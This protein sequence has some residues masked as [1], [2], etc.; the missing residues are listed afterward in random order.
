[1]TRL[2]EISTI[3]N[4]NKTD[5]NNNQ[6]TNKMDTLIH[7]TFTKITI[8]NYI[9]KWFEPKRLS[10]YQTT[11]NKHLST[12]LYKHLHGIKTNDK[13]LVV[14]DFPDYYTDYMYE[15]SQHIT[16]ELYDACLWFDGRRFSSVYL[17]MILDPILKRPET[18]HLQVQE[19]SD[20]EIMEQVIPLVKGE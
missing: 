19:G 14:Q 4:N 9:H 16:T 5:N 15:L 12:C 20:S 8:D 10:N 7:S 18:I 11:F 2:Y 17:L 6:L 13:E 1:M 3:I